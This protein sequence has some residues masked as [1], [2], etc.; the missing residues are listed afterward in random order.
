MSSPGE[1]YSS[2]PPIT[3][4]WGTSV[5]LCTCAVQLG[6]TSP[7]ALALFWPRVTGQLQARAHV[8]ECVLRGSGSGGETGT[9]FS[10]ARA[11]G[12]ASLA[13]AL[14]RASRALRRRY[15]GC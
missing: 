10:H 1:W 6:L 2:L 9:L 7:V 12:R 11:E 14:T 13:E 15:G 5:F 3:K 4:L 8:C